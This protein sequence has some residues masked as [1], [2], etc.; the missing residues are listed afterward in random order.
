M[1]GGLGRRRGREGE[2]ERERQEW[3]C[4]NSFIIPSVSVQGNHAVADHLDVTELVKRVVSMVVC[5]VGSSSQMPNV[6][7][8]NK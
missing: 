3:V 6:R 5:S 8:E 7:N 1:G 4:L 2:G